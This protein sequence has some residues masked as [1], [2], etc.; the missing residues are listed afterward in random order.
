MSKLKKAVLVS[1]LALTIVAACTAGPM[2][3]GFRGGNAFEIAAEE[4][5]DNIEKLVEE[6]GKA[7]EDATEAYPDNA[8]NNPN[9][10]AEY[11]QTAVQLG[12]NYLSKL[13][14]LTKGFLG[15]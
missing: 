3:V 6:T 11:V 13:S 8:K 14:G 15:R 10:P 5:A 2:A 9:A 4:Y 12:N 7:Y 1:T